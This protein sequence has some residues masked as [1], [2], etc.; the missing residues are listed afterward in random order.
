MVFELTQMYKNVSSQPEYL[1]MPALNKNII[2]NHALMVVAEGE[3]LEFLSIRLTTE[4]LIADKFFTDKKCGILLSLKEG[5]F[6]RTTFKMGRSFIYEIRR[7][8]SVSFFTR[9]KNP[10]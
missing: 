2:H 5:R 9:T 1:L 4:R 10:A 6:I 3:K 7:I 8:I